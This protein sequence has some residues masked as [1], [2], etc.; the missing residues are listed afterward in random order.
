MSFSDFLALVMRTTRRT[1]LMT[2]EVIA[3]CNQ[4]VY[5]IAV[6]CHVVT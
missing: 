6:T 3:L 4:K 2:A 5:L 1:I